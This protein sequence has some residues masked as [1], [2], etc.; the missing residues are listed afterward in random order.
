MENEQKLTVHPAAEILPPMREADFQRLKD[1]IELHGLQEPIW[2]YQGRILDGR[3]RYRACV[4]WGIEP[5]TREYEG[6]DPEDFVLSVNLP[7]SRQWRPE[8]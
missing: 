8:R 7:C 2:L 5:A 6:D 1:D 3:N 4:E